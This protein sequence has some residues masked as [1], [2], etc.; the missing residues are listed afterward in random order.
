MNIFEGTRVGVAMSFAAT[1]SKA[2][3]ILW[4][5]NAALCQHEFTVN[6]S[7]ESYSYPTI[8]LR[9]R[10]QFSNGASSK[11]DI[12]NLYLRFCL[13]N[14]SLSWP[15]CDN[16][17]WMTGEDPA[18][19]QTGGIA[20][21]CRTSRS[22]CNVPL[23]S[24]QDWYMFQV[25]VDGTLSKWMTLC[26]PEGLLRMVTSSTTV[27]TTVGLTSKQNSDSSSQTSTVNLE[28]WQMGLIAAGGV[29]LVVLLLII[30]KY[31]GCFQKRSNKY[32]I[33][34]QGQKSRHSNGHM[35]SY[36]ESS[37]H[38]SRSSL[39][40]TGSALSLTRKS[41]DGDKKGVWKDKER[42]VV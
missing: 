11:T 2:W 31:C 30:F 41:N 28:V 33:Q 25:K 6:A 38:G 23:P 8:Q 26:D 35:S 24:L 37:V 20:L 40:A 29:I 39:S 5:C 15:R 22:Y 34:S 32:N 42:S 4:Q 9:F 10:I 18:C 14:A 16:S 7:W 19:Q 13:R 21:A 3:F 36:Q 12:N 27:G 17:S 1:L